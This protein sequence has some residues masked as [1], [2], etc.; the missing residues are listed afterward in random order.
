[1]KEYM[2]CYRF[3][4]RLTGAGRFDEFRKLMI[5]AGEGSLPDA[6]GD[7]FDGALGD[8]IRKKAVL[9]GPRIT[10]G[11]PATSRESTI[12]FAQVAG[13]QGHAIRASAF[14]S[15]EQRVEESH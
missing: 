3:E 2:R 12:A 10:K 15:G 9:N 5:A 8:G 1:M 7:D 6:F 13:E 4:K 14:E 11:T